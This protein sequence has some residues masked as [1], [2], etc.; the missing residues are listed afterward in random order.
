VIPLRMLHWLGQRS[1]AAAAKEF[2]RAVHDPQAAQRARLEA[3]LRRNESTAYGKQYGF[4]DIRDPE[5]Y[6]ERVPVVTP[7][8]HAPWVDRMLAGETNVLTAEAPVYYVQ[9]TGSTGVPKHVPITPSYRLEFQKALHSSFW[10]FYRRYPQACRGRVLYFVGS[11]RDA[12][13]EDGCHVGTMS[14]YNFTAMPKVVRAMYAWPQ[15]LF[16]LRDLRTR[17]YLALHLA[18][19]GAPTLCGTIFPIAVVLLFRELERRADELSHHLERGTLPDDLALSSDERA[20]YQALV[21][22]RPDRARGLR[23]GKTGDLIPN[24]FPELR[25][26]V[27][28][29]GATAGLY[30]D[31][32]QR[33]LGER[34][35]IRDAVY[36]AAE[37]WM[38]V[39]L[40]DDQPGGPICVTGH[41]QEFIP[42]AEFEAGGTN[43]VGA[44]EL[45]EGQR[46]AVVLTTSGGSYRYSLGDV[47]EC[48]GRLANTPSI[49]FVRKMGAH[50]SLVG[51]KLDE[52]HVTLAV[53]GALR[54][55][56]AESIWSCLAPRTGGDLPGY[57]LHI[58]VA[59]TG[60][61]EAWRAQLAERVDRGLQAAA[62]DYAGHRSDTSLGPVEVRLV[63]PGS[64]ADWRASLAAEGVAVAQQKARHLV[65]AAED[66]PQA[67]RGG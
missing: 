1:R 14:G 22:K 64:F 23:A 10:H 39:P 47:V 46:Y 11:A 2:L 60:D 20:F 51:E 36:S 5:A 4:A 12:V 18:L 63:T 27:C 56:G 33:W 57:T 25:A 35:V 45:E 41:Y 38:N 58:E 34:A 30:V 61:P 9:T 67:L 21:T 43:T 28:W 32:L 65:D 7:L 42:Q 37:G 3:I 48:C 24:A 44:H 8:E 17:N 49:R 19:Q 66:V 54:E 26:V 15:E 16:S 29:T 53:G 13:A 50:C 31:E 40:G 62:R 55:L 6:R 59:P 52:A